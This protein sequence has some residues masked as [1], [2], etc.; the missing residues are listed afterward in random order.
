MT[1]RPGREL[2]R[3]PHYVYVHLNGEYEPLYVG[4]TAHPD[5]R[6]WESRNR[7][8]IERE[9]A[10]VVVSPPMSFEAASW[11]EAELITLAQ[12]KHNKRPGQTLAQHASKDWRID[13]IC[14]AEGVNRASAKALVRYYPTDPDEFEAY[15]AQRVEKVRE[16]NAEVE[17]RGISPDVLAMERLGDL[18]ASGLT[19]R[20]ERALAAEA[21]A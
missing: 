4:R 9:S 15:L 13:R 3:L 5:R 19:A 20:A 6:P 18:F 2:E 11:V 16:F 21:V 8:W 7:K 17:R 1:R 10:E 14:E 12:P